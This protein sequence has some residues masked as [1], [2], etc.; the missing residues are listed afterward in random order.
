VTTRSVRLDAL[1]DALRS[2][3]PPEVAG[4]AASDVVVTDVVL[5]TRATTPGALFCCVTGQRVD[6][7]DLA[8]DAVAAGAVAVLAERPVS[9]PAG[10]A[11]LTVDDVRAAMGPVAAAF[12]GHPS[13]SLTVIGITGTNG[14]TTTTQLLRSVFQPTGQATEVIGTLSGLPGD[15]PTTPDAPSL[16]ARLAEHRD[17]GVRVV[18]MEVSSH[19]LALRRVDGTRF[20]ATAFTNLSQDHL[21]LHGTIEN[22]FAAKARLFDPVFTDLAVVNLDDPRGRLLR[23]AATITTV[24]YSLDDVD[25]LELRVDGSRFRWR[26][27]E[28]RLP[29]AGRFN[30]ANALCAAT[31]AL[32]LGVD[33]DHVVAGLA[34]APTV[35]GRFEPVVAGQDF[36]VVVDY[37]HTPDGLQHVLAAA[38]ELVA[39]GAAVRVVFGAG[40]D[41][42]PG[43]R[44]RM[45]EV[46]ARLA[47]QVVVTSDN[48]RSESPGAIIEAVLE[49]IADR[50][51]VVVEPDRRAAIGVALHAARPGDIVVIA[52]KGHE[53]T[54]TTGDSVVPFDDR[55]VVKALLL[56]RAGTSAEDGGA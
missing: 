32:E 3:A 47:D 24:G 30:V 45:G 51:A 11:V 25:D 16:Q 50:R 35:A 4:A 9:V 37:A 42:D 1:L 2:P 54:Q 7:H 15:P 22:Y 38:R 39:P 52:G 48:P 21:D 44:P 13:E 20:A 26:G 33:L 12:W 41:R 53:T 40:G 10:T 17:A 46:A 34:E 28:L 36:D 6:G 31:L 43:K 23:D 29:I 14:K 8:A 55:E 49:G 5:D 27:A 19:G 18:A 56:E